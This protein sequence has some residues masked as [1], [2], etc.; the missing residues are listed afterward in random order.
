[1]APRLTATLELDLRIYRRMRSSATHAPLI[2]A[3]R[4]LSATGEHAMLWTAVGAVGAALDAPR[5]PAWLQGTAA[6]L[7]A[8]ASSSV[9]KRAVRRPRPALDELPLLVGTVSGLSF[10][11]S[12]TTSSFAA[13]Q[14]LPAPRAPVAAAAT[15]MAASRVFLGAHFPSDVLAGALL[16]TLVGRALGPR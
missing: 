1:V 5:R 14:A 3:A 7:V 9:V 16:G 10:P 15:A 2:A 12:H 6:V 4:A 8:H 13:I 11:S